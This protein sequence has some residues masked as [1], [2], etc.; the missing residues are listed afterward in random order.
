MVPIIQT[1]AIAGTMDFAT[2]ANPKEATE[3]AI[4]EATTA[5]TAVAKNATFAASK[6]AGRFVIK[7]TKKKG[8]YQRFYASAKDA[9]ITMNYAIFLAEFEGINIGM[10]E[11]EF[12]FADN[13]NNVN[14][15]FTFYNTF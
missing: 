13:N 11:S 6:A 3:G 9:G 14:A 15:F 8:V 2:V 4:E 1:G 10:K 12:A 5:V 7:L